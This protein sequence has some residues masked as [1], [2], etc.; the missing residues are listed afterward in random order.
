[1]STYLSVAV[2]HHL[3]DLERL[4]KVAV[5]AAARDSLQEAAL[6][7]GAAEVLVLSTC[8]RTE[9]HV[10]LETHDDAGPGPDAAQAAADRLVLLLGGN[11]DGIAKYATVEIGDAAVRQLFRVAAGLD[12]RVVGEVEIQAQLRAAARSALAVQG[13]PH[14]LRGLVAAALAGAGNVPDRRGLLAARAVSRALAR[15]GD[16]SA[17]E[18]VVVGAGT[19]GRQ[20]FEAL[21]VRVTGATLLSR[22]SSPRSGSG[23]RV[24]PLET[25]PARLRQAD[26]IFV[27]TSAGRR[28]MTARLVSEAMCERGGRGLVICDLSV[29]RNVDPAV[30]ATPGVTLLDL[31]D[32]GHAD[33]SG[34][35]ATGVDVPAAERAARAAAD[36]Y[37][38]GVRSRAAGP[39][40]VA[41]RTE[42]EDICLRQLQRVAAGDVSEETLREMA[43]AVAGGVAHQPTV[44]LRAAAAD[45][46]T[47]SMGL[48]ARA[49]GL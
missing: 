28:I 14:R 19:M 8:S 41:L 17:P 3:A 45:G 31:D 6:A 20:I 40:I 4:E 5:K 2:S 35:Q 9:L 22:T 33:P 30:L 13:E 43:H 21:P 25:L 47:A 32:L 49:F 42:I 36:T 37:V 27:A 34:A 29:P 38:A 48:V 10:V 15:A 1:M 7:S 39:G 23:P 44:F 26:V 16:R 12:S 11:Q 46:D 18:V 24:E